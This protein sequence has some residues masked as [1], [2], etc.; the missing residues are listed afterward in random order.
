[1][2]RSILF[3][4]SL[5]VSSISVTSIGL[6]STGSPA[7]AAER[8]VDRIVA[9]VNGRVITSNEVNFL[10]APYAMQLS[11]KFPRRGAEFT[12]ELMQYREETIKELIDRELI[13]HNFDELGGQIPEQAVDQ[14]INDQIAR[15]YDGN[16]ARFIEELKKSNLTLR[17]FRDLTRRKLVV[18][19]MRSSKFDR[20][21]AVTPSEARAEYNKVK[22]EIRDISGDRVTYEKI[23]V[24]RIPDNPSLTPEDQLDLADELKARIEKGEDFKK[25]AEEYSVGANA[26]DG[27]VWKDLKRSD[28]APG[29]ASIV[30]DAPIGK[31]V[32]PLEGPG[33]YVLIKV[34]SRKDGPAPPF[35][36][37]REDM[38][39]RVKARKSAEPFKRWLDRQRKRAIIRRKD[40]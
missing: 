9:T 24:K 11:A 36:E 12:K 30:F 39:N 27:G 7:G 8:V 19:A 13:L 3:S 22:S 14:E 20:G 4:L 33:K 23:E 10:L 18:Q 32:G 28:L 34:L 35:S 15:L 21:V 2:L 29:F 6:L 25:L 1:M 40:K 31:V 26:E 16:R 38:E 37:V 5:G 17:S